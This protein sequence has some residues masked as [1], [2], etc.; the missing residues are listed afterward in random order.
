[1]N[2]PSLSNSPL[3]EGAAGEQPLREQIEELRLVNS[4]LA[5]FEALIS[6]DIQSALRRVSGFSELLTLRPALSSHPAALADLHIIIAAARV[7]DS[8]ANNTLIPAANLASRGARDSVCE[9]HQ[10]T[11][12]ALECRLKDLRRTNHDLTDLADSVARDFRTPLGRILAAT[13]HFATLS[14]VTANPVCLDLARKIL[15]DA[16]RMAHL[17]DDY[18]CFVNSE[19]QS[20]QRARVSLESLIQLV[21]H[22]LEPMCA[23][24]KVTWQISPLPEVEGDPRMLRQVICNLLSNA[25]KYSRK[26][27]ETV[28]EIG[29]RPHPEEVIICVRDNGVG[30]DVEAGRKLF[31][32][33]GRLHNDAAFEGKGIGLVIVKYII[34]RHHGRVWAESSPE[35]GATFCFSLPPAR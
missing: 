5:D 11:F 24:R 4:M 21:R 13:E 8:L 17:I 32:K 30:F 25:L 1:M 33:F 35:G 19:R 22:E 34:E 10:D 16:R 9:D 31:K 3:A 20:V 26:T 2:S 29:V 23:G 6:H 7:I 12:Q 27:P 15:A 14:A 18:L 28:I